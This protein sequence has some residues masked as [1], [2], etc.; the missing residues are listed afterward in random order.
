M[1]S[2]NANAAPAKAVARVAVVAAGVFGCYLI[3]LWTGIVTLIGYESRSAESYGIMSD[4]SGFSSLFPGLPVVWLR[5]GAAIRADYQVDAE[6]GGL[7]LW[8]E[9]PLLL[10]TPLQSANVSIAGKRSGSVL[11]VAQKAG[12]YRYQVYPT[13]IGGK[14]CYPGEGKLSDFI[15]GDS[16]CPTYR[17]R[18]AVSWHLASG[19]LGLDTATKVLI[20]VRGGSLVNVQI[21]P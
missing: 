9:P 11:F 7:R 15:I 2:A 20:P 4:H 3:A 5:Q 10:R 8:A 12:L 19:A 14:N 1:E 13:S 21:G 17:L 18:F 16:K 6:F